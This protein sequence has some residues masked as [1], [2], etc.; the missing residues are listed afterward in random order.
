MNCYGASKF[1][2]WLGKYLSENWNTTDVRNDPD[3]AF[4]EDQLRRYKEVY[5]RQAD[6]QQLGDVGDYLKAAVNDKT[7]VLITVRDS[8][9]SELTDAQREAFRKLG[10][11][12]LPDIK[13]RDS[14]IAVI[15]N[16][17]VIYEVLRDHETTK[18]KEC[19]SYEGVLPDGTEYTLLSGGYKQG[20]KAS[21][22]IDGTEH[23]KNSRGINI[24]LYDNEYSTVVDSAR[25]DTYD[26]AIRDTYKLEYYDIA[27]SGEIPE[28]LESSAIFNTFL[29][30]FDT[31]N[32]N[33]EADRINIMKKNNCIFDFI[34]MYSEDENNI[35]ILTVKDE[36]SQGLSEENRKEL[37][38]KGFEKLSALQFR[39][40]YIGIMEKGTVIYEDTGSEN[41]AVTYEAELYTVISA[42]GNAEGN[43]TSVLI[44]EEEASTQRRGINVVVYNTEDGG[45]IDSV[46]FDTYSGSIHT[47]SPDKK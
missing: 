45:V 30:R 33:R 7:T 18:E 44:N 35:I 25:F 43:T 23:A 40:P 20:D 6:I 19:I 17:K 3:Y 27:K 29:K 1:T 38:E 15:E 16:G 4:M 11:K 9:E 22:V 37:K 8:A 12:K 34:D 21:C 47:L 39:C 13:N 24:V 32:Q 10:L 14:Y 41:S 42:G 31:L 5:Q 26:T 28:E 36:A 2:S 46:F